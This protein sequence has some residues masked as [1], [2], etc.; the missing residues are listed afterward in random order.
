MPLEIGG[1]E[2][3]VHLL[4]G[5]R[6]KH[7]VADLVRECKKASSKWAKEQSKP[8]Q[9]QEG[10]GAFTVGRDGVEAVREYIRNQEVHHRKKTFE[11]EYSELL[12]LAGITV[13]ESELFR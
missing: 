3:H 1:T 7:C 8:I 2:N 12:K 5:M 6:S 9:W 13:E 11:E 4:I 10:Y